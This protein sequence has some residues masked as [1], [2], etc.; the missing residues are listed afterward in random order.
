MQMLQGTTRRNLRPTNPSFILELIVSSALPLISG[1][2]PN[3]LFQDITA[4]LELL[5]VQP[6]PGWIN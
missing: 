2:N 4:S 6:L 1:G 5:Y 3:A